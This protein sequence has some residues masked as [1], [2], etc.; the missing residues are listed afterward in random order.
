MKFEIGKKPCQKG[1]IFASFSIAYHKIDSKVNYSA[2][3][4]KKM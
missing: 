4:Q 2:L 1:D 3:S